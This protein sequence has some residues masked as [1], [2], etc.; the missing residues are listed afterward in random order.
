MWKWKIRQ[1][2]LAP[3]EEEIR[4]KAYE[5]WRQR[6]LSHSDKDNWKDALK[7]LE[8]E[9]SLGFR[10]SKRL[11]THYQVRGKLSESL[12]KFLPTFH[13]FWKWTGISE[14]K[15]WDILQLLVVP[16]VIGLLSFGVQQYFKDKD[17]QQQTI[18]KE[19]Q[20]KSAYR[21]AE[22]DRRSADEK[23][24]QETLVNYL[25]QMAQS[26]KEG[27]LQAKPGEKEFIIAQARTVIALQSLDAKRQHLIIQYLQA[28][29][30][31]QVSGELKRNKGDR[32]Q[33]GEGDR[34]LLYKAQIEKA[35]LKKVT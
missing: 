16:V 4:A 5:L 14:K 31:N 7:A 18:D 12:Q 25:D 33:L 29:G 8:C 13:L 1:E 3:T 30:L 19:N 2:S 10:L 6:G 32:L 15:G 22:Q 24:K 17:A 21:K 34:V 26:L 35:N 9:R 28:A 11:S 23:A 20:E 27:L